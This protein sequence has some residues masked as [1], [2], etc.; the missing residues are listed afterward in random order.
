M[1]RI[2]PGRLRPGQLP[3]DP[4]RGEQLETGERD[5]GGR[6]ACLQVNR[7]A[8]EEAEVALRARLVVREQPGGQR[9]ECEGEQ[10]GGYPAV[11]PLLGYG[12]G[13]L[14]HRAIE[15]HPRQRSNSATLPLCPQGFPTRGTRSPETSTS[16]TRCSATGRSTSSTCPG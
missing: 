12:S 9:E 10:R 1:D 16:P 13:K 8:E 14:C 3:E 7:V 6:E 5:S 4:G 2:D 15:S 11:R